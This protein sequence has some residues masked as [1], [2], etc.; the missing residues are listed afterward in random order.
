MKEGALVRTQRALLARQA[1]R[2]LVVCLYVGA[3]VCLS[4]CLLPVCLSVCLPVCPS[5]CLS[6]CLPACLSIGLSV[7]LSGAVT[8]WGGKLAARGDN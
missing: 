2:T 1:G 6:V 5:V 7:C 8:R 4:V 3:S